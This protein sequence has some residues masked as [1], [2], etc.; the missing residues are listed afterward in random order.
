MAMDQ[1]LNLDKRLYW[2]SW[3]EHLDRNFVEPERSQLYAVLET[4]A[5][6]QEVDQN[7][8]LTALNR[9]GEPVG[10]IALRRL[11]DTLLA[12]GYLSVTNES[13]YCF[14]MNLLRE[15]W[16]RYVIL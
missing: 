5:R 3:R 11:L 14:R 6:N 4:T 1:L 7:I 15:W 12:D 10:E 16:Q 9:R 13:H 8:F 2:S